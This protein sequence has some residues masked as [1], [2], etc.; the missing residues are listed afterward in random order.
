MWQELREGCWGEEQRPWGREPGP[1]R[2]WAELCG[3]R[4]ESLVSFLEPHRVSG[5]RHKFLHKLPK[6]FC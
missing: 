6:R 5:S 2:S 4:L 1:R 3:G